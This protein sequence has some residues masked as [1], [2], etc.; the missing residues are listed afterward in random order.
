M[1][2]TDPELAEIPSWKIET[3][4]SCIPRVFV[5]RHIDWHR[6]DTVFMRSGGTTNKYCESERSGDAEK[7]QASFKGPFGGLL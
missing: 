3:S 2:P 5:Y 1:A 6:S 4:V 7:E